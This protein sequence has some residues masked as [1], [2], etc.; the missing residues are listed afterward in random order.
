MRRMGIR[1]EIAININGVKGSLHNDIW[2]RVWVGEGIKVK[3]R[4]GEKIWDNINVN[5]HQQINDT[6]MEKFMHHSLPIPRRK[7]L[8]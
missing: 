4:I 2:E 8:F 3:H 1:A 6:M 7:F 5:I